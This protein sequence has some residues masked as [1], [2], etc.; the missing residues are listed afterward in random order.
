MAH[1]VSYVVSQPW[2]FP[3]PLMIGCHAFASSPDIFVDKTELD[4]ARWFSRAEVADAI[5]ASDRGEGGEAF[6]CPPRF[7]VANV[8]MRWWLDRG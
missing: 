2:P 6:Q 1:D 4:D 8:L 5:A 3:S 7:A